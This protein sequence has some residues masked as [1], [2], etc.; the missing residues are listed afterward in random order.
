[1][2]AR[3]SGPGEVD[4]ADVF[5]QLGQGDLEQF[6]LVIVV[7]AFS[8]SGITFIKLIGPAIPYNPRWRLCQTGGAT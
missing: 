6:L 3:A 8:A 5:G 4:Q 2:P 1:M 7:G